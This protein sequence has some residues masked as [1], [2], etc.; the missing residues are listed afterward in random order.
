MSK[1]LDSVSDCG[2]DTGFSV[3][4]WLLVSMIFDIVSFVSIMMDLVSFC[5]DDTRFSVF[6]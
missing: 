1:I 6:Q 5:V 2:N 3:C 4:Q